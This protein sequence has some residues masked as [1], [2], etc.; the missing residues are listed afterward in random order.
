MAKRNKY[1]AV[2]VVWE[3]KTFDSTRECYAYKLFKG[4]KL[5][6]VWQ[7]RYNLVPSFEFNGEK[8]RK[9]DMVIDFI[10]D[11]R[12]HKIA[13]DIKGMVTDVAKLKYKM[14][15]YQQSQLLFEDYEEVVWLH[16]NA[17][18]DAFAFK[19]KEQ[20]QKK[21]KSSSSV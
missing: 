11:T 8:V 9:M 14:L 5:P 3:G 1:N 2:K 17:E 21:R 13:V 18:I 15:K 6:F 4:L 12:T 16:S 10:V 7:E 19:L 20:W